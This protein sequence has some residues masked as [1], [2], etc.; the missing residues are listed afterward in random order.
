MAIDVTL[1]ILKSLKTL[2]D[3][4]HV[5][6]EL[7]PFLYRVLNGPLPCND[8]KASICEGHKFL[9]LI[10]VTPIASDHPI[11]PATPRAAQVDDPVGRLS[12]CE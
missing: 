1:F 7:A 5:R 9:D 2:G 8:A 6:E 12:L 11:E 10:E 3:E 4:R